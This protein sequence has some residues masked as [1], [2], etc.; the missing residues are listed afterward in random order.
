MIVA[1]VGTYSLCWPSTGIPWSKHVERQ[2]RYGQLAQS[3][4]G[5]QQRATPPRITRMARVGWAEWIFCFER[6][7]SGTSCSMRR[8]TICQLS[9]C[10]GS[11]WNESGEQAVA[12]GA[13]GEGPGESQGVQFD[14]LAAG[15]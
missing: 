11:E 14:V 7:E 3:G 2:A 12:R 4:A 10:V 6:L 1:A 8:V 5:L 9:V 13:A 15:A